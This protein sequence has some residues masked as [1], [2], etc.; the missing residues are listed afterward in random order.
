MHSK[1]SLFFILLVGCTAA[2]QSEPVDIAAPKE[3]NVAA[4]SAAVQNQNNE[5]EEHGGFRLRQNR[6]FQAQL[7]GKTA[8]RWFEATDGSAFGGT[9]KLILKTQNE[10]D[11]F[12][13]VK[14]S[15]GNGEYKEISDSG[16]YTVYEDTR[17]Q[18]FMRFLM[19]NSGEGFVQL[20][21]KEGRLWLTGPGGTEIFEL[22]NSA[23]SINH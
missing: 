23:V 2:P 14:P 12:S 18:L 4:D 5:W 16:K 7:E 10:I 9:T 3:E 19:K 11:I 21:F 8:T 6:A 15:S 13:N 22:K 20:Q 17:G 1:L